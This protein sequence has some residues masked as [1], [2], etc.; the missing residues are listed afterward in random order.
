[1][2]RSQSLVMVSDA[3]SR[4]VMTRAVAMTVIVANERQA[5][6]QV[7]SSLGRVFMMIMM[8]IMM[9]MMIYTYIRWF[10]R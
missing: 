1:M 6:F 7:F 5:S 10:L 2:R 8:T 4:Q 9:M 3:S